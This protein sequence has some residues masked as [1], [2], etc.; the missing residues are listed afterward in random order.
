MHITSA[1]ALLSVMASAVQIGNACTE[2][3]SDAPAGVKAAPSTYNVPFCGS[4]I[5][6]CADDYGITIDSNAIYTFSAD[7]RLQ[8][9]ETCVS[10]KKCTDSPTGA[11]CECNPVTG[12]IVNPVSKKCLDARN[13]AA[14]EPVFLYTCN[15][16]LHSNW[17]M[18]EDNQIRNADTD[19]CMGKRNLPG[20]SHTRLVVEKCDP[21]N[22][23]LKWT[24]ENKGGIKDKDDSCIDVPDSNYDDGAGIIVY[25]CHYGGNQQWT[26]PGDGAWSCNK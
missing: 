3:C 12:P 16:A 18:T 19:F 23:E 20:E 9:G 11:N 7:G 2:F 24:I 22:P 10:P 26:L 25:G 1:L 21:G 17:M 5:A 4:K 6:E 15:E 8:K 14:G 13:L